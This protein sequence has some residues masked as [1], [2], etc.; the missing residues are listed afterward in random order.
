MFPSHIFYGGF[1]LVRA[2][3][4]R[5]AVAAIVSCYFAL[6]VSLFPAGALAAAKFQIDK[7]GSPD[8]A[9]G[10]GGAVVKSSVNNSAGDDEVAEAVIVEKSVGA[11]FIAGRQ[12]GGTGCSN[13]C[14]RIEK[15]SIVGG[16]LVPGFKQGSSIDGIVLSD[17]GQASGDDRALAVVGDGVGASIYIVGFQTGGVP[18]CNAG[19][20]CWRIE[21][22][23]QGTG[24]LDGTFG[25][26][27]GTP[28]YVA[29]NPATAGNLV[30]GA[31]AIS[32]GSLYIAGQMLNPPGMSGLC[33][34]TSGDHCWRVEKRDVTTGELDLAWGSSGV[35]T[36]NPGQTNEKAV[37]LALD[38]SDNLYVLG[39]AKFCGACSDIFWQ[40]YKYDSAGIL[41]LGWPKLV[42]PGAGNVNNLPQSVV[43]YG[44]GIYVTGVQGTGCPLGSSPNTCWLVQ[45]Y[46]LDGNLV[47]AFDFDGSFISDPSTGDDQPLD[48]VIA[49]PYLYIVGF[50]TTG[51]CPTGGICWRIEKRFMVD[52]TLVPSFDGDG[53]LFSDN[54]IGADQAFAAAIDDKYLYVV[55]Y[56]T[57]GADCAASANCWMVSKFSVSDTNIT[58]TDPTPPILSWCDP[59][60]ASCSPGWT[61]VKPPCSF[62]TS[63]PLVFGTNVF[64]ITCSETPPDVEI[65]YSLPPPVVDLRIDQDGTSVGPFDS[66]GNDG[67]VKTDLSS[68]DDKVV[69]V[70]TDGSAIY[71]AENQRSGCS[72]WCWRIQKRSASNGT[73]IISDQISDPS[74]G[75][76]EVT[77]M[78]MDEKGE[79]IYIVGYQNSNS[80]RIEKR[81][82]S[83]LALVTV[84]GTGGSI[85]RSTGSGSGAR[86]VAI[87]QTFLYVA[88]D[89]IGGAGCSGTCWRIEKIKLADG[90]SDLSFGT[91]GAVVADFA[92]GNDSPTGIA[93]DK[94]NIF[95]AGWK[96]GTG[97][98][99][100]GRCWRMV[101]Y[102]KT[103]T[104]ATL[105]NILEDL[106]S[107]TDEP[108][109]I[110]T[111][112]S[113]SLLA[114]SVFIVGFRNGGG[115]CSGSYDCWRVEQR[116][117]S[118]GGLIAVDS[119]PANRD[120][121]ATSALLDGPYLYVGG[122]QK[123]GGGGEQWR[124]EKYKVSPSLSVAKFSSGTG[125]WELYETP[126]D[127]G[128]DRFL[129]M[130]LKGKYLYLA[131]FTDQGGDDGLLIQKRLI[132]E[133]TL[134]LFAPANY[135]L[136]WKTSGAN[137][138]SGSITTTLGSQL[139]SGISSGTY[140]Y[141]MN[142]S[143]GAA[144]P[145]WASDTVTVNVIPAPIP[146]ALNVSINP[147]SV[148]PFSDPADYD[149]RWNTNDNAGKFDGCVASGTP[150]ASAAWWTG[151]KSVCSSG[152]C[153]QST[154]SV[155][156]GTH[157]Y[158]MGCFPTSEIQS[159]V[160][161]GSTSTA[162]SITSTQ[163]IAVSGNRAYIAGNN[164]LQIADITK[165][166]GSADPKILGSAPFG[167]TV[168]AMAVVGTT[169]YVGG[170][171]IVSG[172]DNFKVFDVSGTIPVLQGTTSIQGIIQGIAV[173]GSYAYVVSDAASNDLDVINISVPGTP[174]P[175][176]GLNI[177]DAGVSDTRKIAIS[178]SSLYVLN[179]VGAGKE[180]EIYDISGVNDATAP[181]YLGG[182]DIIANPRAVAVS[183]NY[184][185]VAADSGNEFL[186]F[187]VANPVVTGVSLVASRDMGITAATDIAVSGVY[188]YAT[189]LS[190]GSDDDAEIFNIQDPNNP[191]KVGGIDLGFDGY[192]L[193]SLIDGYG[194]KYLYAG[195]LS[196]TLRVFSGMAYDSA[197]AVVAVGN[198]PTVTFC[199]SQDVATPCTP[200]IASTGP[201]PAAITPA[202]LTADY[203]DSIALKW[204]ISGVATVC[205]AS[206]GDLGPPSDGWSGKVIALPPGSYSWVTPPLTKP[207]I[208]YTLQ[209]A[210]TNIPASPGP[211][212]YGP[213]SVTVSVRAFDL[214][215]QN[216]PGTVNL[217]LTST[218]TPVNIGVIKYGTFSS[219][220]DLTNVAVINILTSNPVAG[221]QVIYQDTNTPPS[222]PVDNSGTTLTAAEYNAGPPSEKSIVLVKFPKLTSEGAYSLTITGTGG[223]FSDTETIQFDVLNKF[224]IPNYEPF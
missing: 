35:I 192:A 158:N 4:R 56:Q 72:G 55:G 221:A 43:V 94:S 13:Y 54:I 18:D 120:S 212:S 207:S 168:Y 130:A 197:T 8:T 78:V 191:N 200:P 181:A 98:T 198:P 203:G 131:G 208:T 224:V 162:P 85:T 147:V 222:V 45:K 30:A 184:A 180:L 141:T 84:F 166:G 71:L 91:S 119:D 179:P 28:G 27:L 63:S 6:A 109:A 205:T 9:F 87:D 112:G 187:D 11:I 211:Q 199:A 194:H 103:T 100:G 76:D 80:W 73:T 153:S 174:T 33:G 59:D 113:P 195:G 223:G 88:G 214:M 201:V 102:S 204:T 123:Q 220:V 133:S 39:T 34:G 182:A 170:D 47:P 219:N 189:S 154:T 175:V 106:S 14:W 21:K 42:G 79:F 97:C 127:G 206:G 99:S 38:S 41:V 61:G 51:G 77:G 46:D 143:N 90:T 49:A 114:G 26:G 218:T 122:Y 138:C 159:P 92:G 60:A 217:K 3:K 101:K 50:Q 20:K 52:G 89:Q 24:A 160:F 215:S 136:S 44:Q 74:G 156:V 128:N 157:T 161:V 62:A 69:S 105:A 216:S 178:G 185:Y 118:L 137:S 139:Y 40:L 110:T 64:G 148:F 96:D 116:N 155:P 65:T 104:G 70:A 151:P 144:T 66:T 150:V 173:S 132:A 29:V 196:S 121:R 58:V 57:G 164:S 149:V 32:G 16:A 108:T 126:A 190:S 145:I 68:G 95:V 86:A 81:Y 129:S 146:P 53:V 117:S 165:S 171:G 213:I 37:S 22:R 210:N 17:P 135:T 23:S 169:A 36:I 12:K 140:T 107:N 177:F 1:N 176:V 19:R 25:L 111:D 75:N 125:D 7:N 83:D 163:D 15:R 124:V 142:C 5:I 115:G 10:S 209:C 93:A 188:A 186:V 152:T 202:T 193:E 172:V 2:R 31:I 82:T 134:N 183:G 67:E 167:G 48:T